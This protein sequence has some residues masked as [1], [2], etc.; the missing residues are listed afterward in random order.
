L[1]VSIE[2]G[3]R[4]E[5]RAKTIEAEIDQLLEKRGA[6]VKENDLENT[7]RPSATE[8]RVVE[9]EVVPDMITLPPEPQRTPGWWKQLSRG[10]GARP[11]TR[12][13]FMYTLQT[14]MITLYGVQKASQLEIDLGDEDFCSEICTRH[15]KSLEGRKL[16][17]S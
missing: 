9:S 11:I 13:A 15:C 4:L 8:P 2:E 17:K 5:K 10:D 12:E 7:S 14:V 3:E 1:I 16:G 6:R